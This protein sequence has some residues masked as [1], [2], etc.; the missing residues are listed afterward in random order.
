MK[1]RH[2]RMAIIARG[3]AALGI[4][5][6]LVLNAFQSN[7]VFFFSPPRCSPT[8]RRTA[9][10][11]ASAAWSRRAASNAKMTA[12]RCTS[13]SPTPRRRYPS[14]TRASCPTCSKRA[15][16]WW[17]RAS[18]GPDG[19]FQATEVLAKHDENYMPPEARKHAIEQAQEG[20]KERR[21]KVKADMI[22]EI[23]HFA[24]I[25]ALLARGH[26]GRAADR[27]RARGNGGVDGARASGCAR[28]SS[29][30]SR[31]RS[32]AWRGRS[33]HNDFS[34]LN[35][36]TNSNSQLPM[37]YRLAATWGSHEG[38]LLLWVLMLNVLDGRGCGVQPAPA[39]A[40]GG[41]R[42]RRD[43]AR[44]ASASCCSCCSRPTRSS[45]CFRRRPTAAT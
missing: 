27:G 15:K 7:L 9:R 14:P 1:P 22:P 26:A 29:R 21:H 44:S 39:R 20:A 24:L 11:S 13:W 36:A 6:A 30:S 34:V 37:P 10:P 19:E 33:S 2:K 5:A 18:C 12:S 40:D 28:R 42:A 23:G 45:A 17:R 43:G 16:A 4:A 3:L 25:L 38:S 41:A 35:V 8:K 31:S 32:A